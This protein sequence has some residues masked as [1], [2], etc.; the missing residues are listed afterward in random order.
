MRVAG[1]I[2]LIAGALLCA[3]LVW[4]DGWVPADGRRPAV[5]PGGREQANGR[6][7]LNV[8]PRAR[9]MSALPAQ[10]LCRFLE[11]VVSR[12]PPK[13]TSPPAVSYD[14]QAW[15]QLVESDVDLAR[16]TSVLADYGQQYVDELASEYLADIDKQRLP[17]IVE[18]SSE[19]QA[20]VLR[21][22]AMA[23]WLD[24]ARPPNPVGG[25]NDGAVGRSPRPLPEVTVK[26]F[27][28]IARF[29][30][31]AGRTGQTGTPVMRPAAAPPNRTGRGRPQQDDRQRG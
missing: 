28:K 1:W 19:G 27:R 13:P 20:R 30:V 22:M 12:E 26:A 10:R 31:L 14:R 29:R 15:R 2:L 5:T 17:D 18:G 8:R 21:R 25:S 4:A 9:P 6:E 23:G 24:D 16:I 7:R 11:P 3:T